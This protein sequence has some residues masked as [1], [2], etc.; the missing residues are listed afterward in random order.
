MNPKLATRST[1]PFSGKSFE[2]RLRSPDAFARPLALASG[3]GRVPGTEVERCDAHAAIR[4]SVA[5]ILCPATRLETTEI[6][7]V[8]SPG[9]KGR[10]RESPFSNRHFRPKKISTNRDGMGKK[11]SGKAPSAESHLFLTIR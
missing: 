9:A 11:V 7:E 5:R 6:G 10:Q 4:L 1:T 8:A 3:S 2:V